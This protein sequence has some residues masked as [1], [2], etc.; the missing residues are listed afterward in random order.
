MT[1]GASL[2]LIAVG[3]ILK[4]AVTAT[5]SGVDLQTIGVVLMVVGAVG[6]VLGLVLST[7]RRRIDVVQRTD[8]PGTPVRR[9][10][11]G[12]DDPNNPQY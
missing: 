3:A 12:Q 8:D 7:R 9:A 11:Y 6:L 2:L 1:I 5:L 4:F 10:T